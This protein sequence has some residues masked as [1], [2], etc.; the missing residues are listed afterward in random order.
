MADD[1]GGCSSPLRIAAGSV[2]LC[3]SECVHVYVYMMCACV[4]NLSYGTIYK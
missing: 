3:A 4:V 1:K 2:S